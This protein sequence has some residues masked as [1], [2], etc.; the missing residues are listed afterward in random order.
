MAKG[1]VGVTRAAEKIMEHL[2]PDYQLIHGPITGDV[3]LVG[4]LP[5]TGAPT[6]GAGEAVARHYQPLD[7]V[8]IAGQTG[9]SLRLAPPFPIESRWVHGGLAR[10]V[11]ATAGK[12]AGEQQQSEM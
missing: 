1:R 8:K 10:Y 11:E 6:A 2:M 12:C 5:M 4:G 3:D 9:T 7:P